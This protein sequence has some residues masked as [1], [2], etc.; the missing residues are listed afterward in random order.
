[1]GVWFNSFLLVFLITFFFSN[2]SDLFSFK[3]D[4]GH[5]ITWR[6]WHVKGRLRT[7]LNTRPSRH[8]EVLT[9]GTP[10]P[11]IWNIRVLIGYSGWNWALH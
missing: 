2:T 1:M 9:C 10:H 3:C 4:L 7:L 5:R 6:S 11:G 8:Q